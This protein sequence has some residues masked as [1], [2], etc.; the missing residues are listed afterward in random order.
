M[1]FKTDALL[2]R[3]AD[4]GENDKMVTLLSAERG[5]FGAAMK[6]VRRQG[7]KLRFAAQPFCFAEYTVAERSGRKTV[8]SAF[9]YDGFYALRESV[10]TFYAAAS[11]TEICDVL[12]LEGMACG[13]LLVAA[14]GALEEFC[15]GGSAFALVRFLLKALQFAGYPVRAENVCPVCGA[16]LSGRMRFD[17]ERGA[18]YCTGCST[19]VP[20]S[21][22]TCKTVRAAL[23]GETETGEDG[24]RRALR[25]LLA[26]L[27]YHTESRL[28]VCEEYVRM[29]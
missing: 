12:S 29:V 19:G 20:A 22:S 24:V 10:E 21:E 16:T 14:V 28:S 26:Y 15:G 13:K 25:L 18:F 5:K 1:D 4:Y 9:L 8:T 23:R 7:A 11:V 27:N 17:M 6:G 3:A 2:L